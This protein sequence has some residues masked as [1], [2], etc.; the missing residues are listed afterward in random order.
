M[1]ALIARIDE[2]FEAA[3]ERK[4]NWGRNEVKLVYQTAKIQAVTE[5]LDKVLNDTD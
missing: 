5:A 2:L 3:L 1:A 4:T